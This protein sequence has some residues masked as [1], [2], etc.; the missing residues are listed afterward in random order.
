[1]ADFIIIDKDKVL[2]QSLFGA[3][4]VT[5]KPGNITANGAATLGGKKLCVVG[6]EKDV[7]IAD[8]VYMTPQ[9][10][11]PGKGTVKIK[12]LGSD[13]QAQKTQTAGKKVILKGSMFD[14]ELEVTQPAK[15][16]PKGPAAPVPD[17]TPKYSGKGMFVT[18]N[19][20]WKGA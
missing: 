17:A 18:N 2:F 15:E 19:R 12:A 13:Q 8:C 3:A 5:P 14:A 10:C 4:I 11:I 20:K 9:Y 7:Q 1:M 6:D 16:P